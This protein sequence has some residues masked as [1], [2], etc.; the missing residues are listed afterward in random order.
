MKKSES[1]ARR[2][3]WFREYEEISVRSGIYDPGKVDW[4]TATYLLSTGRS[5]REAVEYQARNMQTVANKANT[6]GAS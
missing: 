4:D 5:P 6:E 1:F 2:S 3:R